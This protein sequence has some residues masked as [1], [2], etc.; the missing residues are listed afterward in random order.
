MVGRSGQMFNKCLTAAGLRRDQVRL[1]NLVPCRAPSDTFARHP[2]AEVAWGLAQLRKDLRALKPP[3]TGRRVFVL[4]GS[5]PL[6]WF[7]GQGPIGKWRG[8][9]IPPLRGCNG[10]VHNQYWC[11][12]P[13][14]GKV[15]WPGKDDVAFL[16]TYHPSAVL[17]QMEWHYWLIND[18]K[19]AGHYVRGRDFPRP[20]RTWFLDDPLALEELVQRLGKEAPAE[21]PSALEDQLALPVVSIDTEMDPLVTSLVTEDEVHVF[22]WGEEYA[23]ALRE[24]MSHPGILKLA[25][26]MQHDWRQFEKVYGVPVERPWFDT[27]AGAHCLEPGGTSHDDE[28]GTSGGEQQVGK[29]LSPSISSRFT[30]W[31]FHKWLV[32]TDDYAY[33]GMDSVVSYDAFLEQKRI[34]LEER[35]ELLPVLQQ[36]MEMFEC[37][38][39][40]SS[41]GVRIDEEARASVAEDLEGRIQERKEELVEL[42]WPYVEDAL[43]R[44]VLKKPDLFRRE[45]QCGCCG[46]GKKKRECCWGCAGFMQSPTKAGVLQWL[47]AMEPARLP[48]VEGLKKAELEAEV[49]GPCE[50]CQGEGGVIEDLGIN[51][52]SSAQVADLFYRALRIPARRY[53]GSETTRFEQL[54]RLLTPGGYLAPG[55][56][57]DDA[58]RVVGLYVEMAKL[59]AEYGTVK[60][61]EP[62]VDGRIRTTFDLWYTPTHR[63][64]SREGLLDVGTNLQ[65]V[66]Y[67]GRRFFISDPGEFFIY[68][69]YAQI[70][71]R[72]QAVLSGDKRLLEIYH[73]DRD[74]H[75]EVVRL[76]KE[77][78]GLEITRDQSKRVSYAAFYDIEPPHLADILGISERQAIRLLQAFFAAFPG[79][80]RY[81]GKVEEELR[82]GRSV[83]SPTGWKRRWLGYVLETRGRRKGSVKKKVRKEALATVPQNMAA[84]VMAE[85]LLRIWREAR[86]LLSPRIHVHDSGLLATPL[87][88]A[89]EGIQLSEELMTVELWGMPFPVTAVCGPDWLTASVEDEDK[90]AGMEVWRRD[91]L[92]SMGD[93][94]EL[95]ASPA[96]T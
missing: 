56:G 53:Q 95:A 66:P 7:L 36:D 76:I 27:I 94:S 93:A 20:A 40:A 90:E 39:R 85:G 65:N 81:K 8:S 31:P 30:G 68:P 24:L 75:M 19:R 45:R 34:L 23:E 43:A 11:R 26:N 73:S 28:H 86:D 35:R 55:T 32:E 21:M 69:D 46:G 16:P 91:R 12:L 67:I 77:K 14:H 33:C 83:S 6:D 41:I 84:Y 82:R 57:R 88:R 29:A 5:N 72:C 74:S 96:L 2:E 15:S 70:E 61:L 42:A 38:F 59:R 89:G 37:L 60:R 25:H 9:L 80:R 78:T 49:F 22:T 47:E 44:G 54:E 52:N 79:A 58:R 13:L 50:V 10:D 71:G 48:Q 18:L 4:M 87:P 1:M 63:V 51:L 62:D 64:A 17:R 3:S 92:L